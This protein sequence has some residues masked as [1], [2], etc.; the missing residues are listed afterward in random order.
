MLIYQVFFVKVTM[1]T[2]FYF[3]AKD[4]IFAGVNVWIQ[5]E[6]VLIG[7]SSNQCSNVVYTGHISVVTLLQMPVGTGCKNVAT[8]L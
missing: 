3:V 8:L 5:N 2:L 6:L 7:N 1:V 4:N